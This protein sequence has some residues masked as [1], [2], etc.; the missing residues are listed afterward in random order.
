MLSI[1]ITATLGL[2]G[3]V[4]PGV[5]GLD[6]LSGP[7]GAALERARG[8]ERLLL[9]YFWADTENCR[10]LYNETMSDE[11][12]VAALSEQVLYSADARPRTSSADS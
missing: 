8:T 4:E 12:V 9:T 10:R 7:H 11:G 2:T 1:L 6:W 5:S 3:P